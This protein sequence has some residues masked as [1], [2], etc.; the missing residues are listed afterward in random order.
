MAEGAGA[1]RTV[2][3]AVAAAST[4]STTIAATRSIV[5]TTAMNTNPMKR[6]S[7]GSTRGDAAERALASRPAAT[8]A[9]PAAIP[10]VP[11]PSNRYAA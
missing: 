3:N 10:T 4:A 9:V 7:D 6:T 11:R 8:Y 1:T 2:A 5:T